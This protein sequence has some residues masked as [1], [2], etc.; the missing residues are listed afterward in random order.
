MNHEASVLRVRLR[1][2]NAI[3]PDGLHSRA[4]GFV[5]PLKLCVV[6]LIHHVNGR[7]HSVITN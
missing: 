6:Y 3:T 1:P 5:L 7:N 2:K 4:A